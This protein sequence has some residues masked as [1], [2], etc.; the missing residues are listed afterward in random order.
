MGSCICHYQDQHE[1]HITI[2]RQLESDKKKFNKTKKILLLGSGSSGTSTIFKQL[3]LIN[4]KG[5]NHQERGWI[6]SQIHEQCI[7][8]MKLALVLLEEYKDGGIEGI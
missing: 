8:D 5:F 2:A 3:R 6:L 4:G 1:K 7:R